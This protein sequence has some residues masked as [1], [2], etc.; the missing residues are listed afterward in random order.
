MLSCLVSSHPVLAEVV[1]SCLVLYLLDLSCL[2]L[3]CLFLYCNVLFC[4]VNQK[5]PVQLNALKLSNVV[6][7]VLASSS[8]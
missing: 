6:L 2:I 3:S 5:V 8:I 7:K 1:S 4:V